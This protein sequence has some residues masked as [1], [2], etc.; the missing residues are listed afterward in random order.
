M[1]KLLIAVLFV[2]LTGAASFAQTPANQSKKQKTEQ[3]HHKKTT[4]KTT[5][6]TRHKKHKAGT[7]TKVDSTKAAH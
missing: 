7:K 1:K 3:V 2:A 5:S 6:H 4:T